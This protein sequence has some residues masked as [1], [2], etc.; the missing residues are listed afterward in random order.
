MELPLAHTRIISVKVR[1]FAVNSLVLN[2]YDYA[3]Y[4][5][6][7]NL[8]PEKWQPNQI[9]NA[10]CGSCNRWR[11]ELCSTVV[12]C[13]RTNSNA[14]PSN[15]I[16]I[17]FLLLFALHCILCLYFDVVFFLLRFLNQSKFFRSRFYWCLRSV[18]FHSFFFCLCFSM[19]CSTSHEIHKMRL[20][21]S[22]Y[23]C[24][25]VVFF[26]GK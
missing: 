20:V 21:V 26:L 15:E 16:I 22:P 18:F 7:C 14:K 12:Y 25:I 3:M 19:D 13:T 9:T 4:A 5:S 23:N 6:V 11:F 17:D 1:S 8:Y 10:D 2:L 24:L